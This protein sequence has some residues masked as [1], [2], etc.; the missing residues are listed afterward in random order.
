MTN[1]STNTLHWAPLQGIGLGCEG[2]FFRVKEAFNTL[3]LETDTREEPGK[4]M[5]A[6]LGISGKPRKFNPLEIG[7]C[8]AANAGGVM[9]LG[10]GPDP[11]KA[12]RAGLSPTQY[13]YRIKIGLELCTRLEIQAA[14]S[15]GL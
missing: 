10:F 7:W 14:G 8:Y 2:K 1:P 4:A 13:T 9:F 6:R 12:P 11:K 3:L 15:S 5:L